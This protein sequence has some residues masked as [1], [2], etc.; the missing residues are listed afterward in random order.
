MPCAF[1]NSPPPIPGVASGDGTHSPRTP[2]VRPGGPAEVTDTCPQCREP[3]STPTLLTSMVRYY[4][5][6][7][8]ARSWNVPRD[9]RPERGA[10]PGSQT[11]CSDV[12]LGDS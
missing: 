6:V 8:C 1:V 9:L 12:V 3:S 7:K 5:C 10:E 2:R 11:L 4:L